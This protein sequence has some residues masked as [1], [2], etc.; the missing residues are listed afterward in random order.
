MFSEPEPLS[1]GSVNRPN[2]TRPNLTISSLLALLSGWS[3]QVGL[4]RLP[5]ERYNKSN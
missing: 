5:G 4:Q 2:P 3:S 1:R